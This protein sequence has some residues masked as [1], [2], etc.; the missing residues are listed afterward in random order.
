MASTTSFRDLDVWQEA[1][2]LVEEIYAVSKLFP[3]DEI[4]GLTAQIRKAAVSV[5][6]NIGEGS[7]RKKRG[8]RLNHFDIALG[9]QGEV[10]VQ[11]EIARRL[12]YCS[13]SDYARL[14]ERIARI[15]RMLN[16][17]ITSLQPQEGR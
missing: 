8:V 3:R 16:G 2:T 12:A 13:A 15:G 14:Q 6:S 11:L 4:F 17:L 9:S 1:M 7:R 10:E 5:P